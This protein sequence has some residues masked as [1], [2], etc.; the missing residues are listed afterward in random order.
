MKGERDEGMR[1]RA[2]RRTARGS[3]PQRGKVASADLTRGRRRMRE[4]DGQAPSLSLAHRRGRRSLFSIIPE[5]D[6]I[7][8]HSSFFIFHSSTERRRGTAGGASPSPT[9]RTDV[10]RETA[11][12]GGRP[13]VAPT[14][15]GADRW[16]LHEAPLRRGRGGGAGRGAER[17]RGEKGKKDFPLWTGKEIF[18]II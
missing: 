15:V 11:R 10:A 4:S 17:K 5:G 6:T 2:G 14:G 18:G 12:V 8:F 3:F 1:T 13:K 7:I 9:E 16:A